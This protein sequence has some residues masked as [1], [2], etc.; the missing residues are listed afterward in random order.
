MSTKLN[1]TIQQTCFSDKNENGCAKSQN[2][3]VIYPLE[4]RYSRKKLILG[5]VNTMSC[6]GKTQPLHLVEALQD[7]LN[8][9]VMRLF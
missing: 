6:S 5:M 1:I 2:D 3:I 7:C 4:F 9:V 8:L